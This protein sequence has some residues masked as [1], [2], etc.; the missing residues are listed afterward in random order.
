MARLPTL[1]VCLLALA[2]GTNASEV[3]VAVATNFAATARTLADAFAHETGHRAV[4]SDGSTGKLYAQIVSGAPFEVFLSAD[5]ERP[6]RLEEDGRAVA[7]S[8][9]TYALG[10]LVLWSPDPA[11]VDGPDALARD[12][13]RHLAIANPELAPY[14]AA[15]RQVLETLGQWERLQPRLVRGEDVGQTF[16]FVASASAELGFV[17]L[18]QVMGR[19]GSRWLVP[20]DG[21]APLEQQAV[22]LARGEGDETARA[23]LDFLRGDAAREV[24]EKAGY[25]LPAR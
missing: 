14:G 4:T 15:A 17:A 13:F 11:R 8:R 23:V 16:H 5:V 18:S 19:D 2:P 25:G 9:F 22:L 21:H 7:G 20:P 6:R 10:R 3:H 24:I 1:V 12:D